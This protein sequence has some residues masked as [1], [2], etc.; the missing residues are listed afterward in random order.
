VTTRGR[1]RRAGIALACVGLLVG[2][3]MAAAAQAGTADP[4]PVT[5]RHVFPVVSRIKP[6][7]GSYHHDYPAT[8]IFTPIG[9]SV[10]A[11]TDGVVDFVSR[12]DRWEPDTNRGADR[13]GLCVS[14]VGNDGVRYYTSHLMFVLPGIE[15]GVRV[16]A[17]ELIALSGQSGD[18]RFTAPHV[19]FGISRPSYPEDWRERRG[20]LSPYAF[21]KAWENGEEKVPFR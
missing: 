11:V 18:A 8:D 6:S 14:I 12:V 10:V 4:G 20:T 19:H 3:P 5:H 16:V 2:W 21:L 13:G 7:F 15:A 1:A 17:G 9:S